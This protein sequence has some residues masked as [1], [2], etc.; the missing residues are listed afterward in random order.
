MVG[1]LCSLLA[2][3]SSFDLAFLSGAISSDAF[4]AS[5]IFRDDM[6]NVNGKRRHSYPDVAE[7]DAHINA[8]KELCDKDLMFLKDRL[9]AH[10]RATQR[11]RHFG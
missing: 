11:F 4:L 3:L 5:L 9:K 7:A 2:P 6:A 10:C 8:I 1:D